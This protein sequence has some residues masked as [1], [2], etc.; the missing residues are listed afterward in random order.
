MDRP[1][2]NDAWVSGIQSSR[3]DRLNRAN[4][5]ADTDDRIG[6]LVWTRC[7]RALPD[8]LDLERVRGCGKW[9]FVGND[10][11]N[12]EAT[13]DMTTEDRARAVE[14]AALDDG[15]GSPSRFFRRLQ[16]DKHVSHCRVPRQ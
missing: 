11:S 9:A 13:I 7:V 4:E 8:Q 3:Y 10:L 14:R 2:G 6:R 16:D 12:S 1:N 5:R 15:R